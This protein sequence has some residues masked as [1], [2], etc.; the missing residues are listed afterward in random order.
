MSTAKSAPSPLPKGP[1][2]QPKVTPKASPQLPDIPQVEFDNLLR[3]FPEVTTSPDGIVLAVAK[4]RNLDCSVSIA[5]HADFDASGFLKF[6]IDRYPKIEARLADMEFEFFLDK[7]LN[8]MS[9]M[10]IRSL[11]IQLEK[12]KT[13][14]IER[15]IE[16]IQASSRVGLIILLASCLRTGTPAAFASTYQSHPEPTQ[17]SDLFL[18]RQYRLRST[19]PARQIAAMRNFASKKNST[20]SPISE[21]GPPTRDASPKRK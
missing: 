20:P 1:L 3:T 17:S 19:Y 7:E 13:Q 14:P 5:P 10:D 15:N 8:K 12:A 21:A 16:V 6:I 18:E 9:T 4:L 11:L 2:V